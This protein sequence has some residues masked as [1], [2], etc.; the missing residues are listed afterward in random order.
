MIDFTRIDYL[1]SGNERQR[2][3]YDQLTKLG[4]FE[5]LSVYHPLLTGTIPIGIDLPE[6]D[7]DI[8]CACSDHEKFA[9]ELISHF[10]NEADFSIRT[11]IW[12]GLTS[13][14]AT[15]RSEDFE[16]EIFGQN[17][18]THLQ[19]AYR[20]M[21]IEHRILSERD[22]SFKLEI[23]QLKR[24]GM[25]TE[26]AFAKLLGLTGDPYAALLDFYDEIT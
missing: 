13:T 7:L 20:H 19:N 22:T 2:R 16:L 4:I 18:P 12:G 14:I 8:I 1:Q 25:K 6:S 17:C 21:I 11:S 26:P 9:K 24:E 5:V 10:S 3:A 15:F 23:I